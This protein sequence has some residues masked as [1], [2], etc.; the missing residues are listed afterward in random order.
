MGSAFNIKQ[1]IVKHVESRYSI[2]HHNGQF[3][4]DISKSFRQQNTVMI[5][6]VKI[7]SNYGRV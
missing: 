6:I 7:K 1:I 3:T 4:K 2:Q 5:M